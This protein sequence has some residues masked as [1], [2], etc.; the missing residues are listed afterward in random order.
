[1]QTVYEENDADQWGAFRSALYHCLQ[2]QQGRSLQA[3]EWRYVH[4]LKPATVATRMGLSAG[5]VRVLLHRARSVL[6]KCIQRKMAEG[7]R[8]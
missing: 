5:A 3:L 6:R 7:A 8:S 4:D 2:R 1:L